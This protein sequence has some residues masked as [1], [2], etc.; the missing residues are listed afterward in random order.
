LIYI[1]LR[2]PIVKNF[3]G[4]TAMT[5]YTN[6]LMLFKELSDKKVLAAFDAGQA[7]SDGG[8]LLLRELEARIGVI[9]RVAGVIRD[10][11][12]PGYIEHSVEDLLKQRVFQIASGYEDGNDCDSLRDDPAM[13][14]AC[15]KLPDSEHVLASQPTMCRFENAPSRTD[16]YRIGAAIS[17]AFIDSYLQAPKAII[18]DID[19]TCDEIH[20]AQQLSLFNAYHDNYCFLP[21]HIYEGQSGKLV[22]AILRPGK[23]PNGKE[24]AM[25]FK[26]LIKKI[27]KAWPRVQIIIRGDS[28]YASPEIMDF[29]EENNIHFIFGLT[30]NKKTMATAQNIMGTALSLFQ[31]SGKPIKLY[32]EFRYQAG[33]WSKARRVIVKAEHNHI[34]SNTRFIVTNIQQAWRKFL[35]EKLYCGRGMMELFI[36]EHKNHL[37]SD[38]T[39]CSGFAANQFRLFLHSLAYILLHTLRTKYLIHT[40][41]AH[42]QFNT[43]RNKLLKIGVEV[44]CLATRVKISMPSSYPYQKDFHQVWL[45]VCTP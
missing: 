3:V 24:V 40:E 20:G 14:I 12:H 25:I 13:K 43:I 10:R 11:R 32:S 39:S 22:T 38:R 5:E 44:R 16:L 8:L 7:S 23:R 28:H 36:K 21:I 29:C 37:A 15:E 9:S 26:R 1:E 6:Q 4:E 34:G 41:W 30:P 2:D 27:K 19:D 45:A 42:A 35:Y 17:D 18:L 31:S 33:T